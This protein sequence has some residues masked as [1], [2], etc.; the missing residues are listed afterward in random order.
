MAYGRHKETQ[1]KEQDTKPMLTLFVSTSS[2]DGSLAMQEVTRT[3]QPMS[4]RLFLHILLD[5]LSSCFS[6][7]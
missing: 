4:S 2:P 3:M 6:D 1:G 7:S 5:L